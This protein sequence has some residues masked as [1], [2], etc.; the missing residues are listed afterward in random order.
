MGS[1]PFAGVDWSRTLCF[2]PPAKRKG[3]CPIIHESKIDIL[4]VIFRNYELIGLQ[5]ET[6]GRLFEPSEYR[7]IF[8]DNT[9]DDEK[10]SSKFPTRKINRQLQIT[11]QEAIFLEKGSSRE[12][13]GISHGSAIDFGLRH[14]ESEICGILDS[15]FFLTNSEILKVVI[16]DF[17]VQGGGVKAMGAEYNDGAS[18]RQWVSINPRN[19]EEIPCAFG[20]FYETSLA[21]SAS[22]IV[23]PAEVEAN[24]TTGFVEVG[25][26]IRREILDHGYKTVTWKTP[27][28]RYGDCEFYDGN[29]SLVGFHLVAGSH[30]RWRPFSVWGIR[31]RLRAY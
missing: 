22:W 8:I 4:I 12:F 16:R 9:P 26:R 29:G 3:G 23:T 24:R 13:D 10:K 30:R 5:V 25:Y 11:G 18:T 31:R 2:L 6:F 14:V 20:S 15:D 21:R 19:F 27:A 1:K 28:T 7:L 17:S